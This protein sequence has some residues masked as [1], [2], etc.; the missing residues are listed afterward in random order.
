MRLF[1]ILASFILTVLG[2][3]LAVHS[4]YIW[5]GLL[6]SLAGFV[7]VIYLTDRRVYD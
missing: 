3:I 1:G 7:N 5:T 6:V 4:P 2:I